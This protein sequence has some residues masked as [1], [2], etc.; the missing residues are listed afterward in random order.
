MYSRGVEKKKRATGWRGGIKNDIFLSAYK[1]FLLNFYMFLQLLACKKAIA[2][3]D[4][5]E[6]VVT[7]ILSFNNVFEN[8]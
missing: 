8:G 7:E 2:K 6:F 5:D 4:E 1:L 3:P